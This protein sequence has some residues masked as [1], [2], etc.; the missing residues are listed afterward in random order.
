MISK[1]GRER[2]RAWGK[3]GGMRCGRKKVGMRLVGWVELNRHTWFG[4]CGACSLTQ[5]ALPLPAPPPKHTR[6]WTLLWRSRAGA[7]CA[8]RERGGSA[9]VL[10]KGARVRQ[11]PVTYQPD[12]TI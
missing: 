8:E 1:G 3:A 11:Q 9:G 6:T 5:P 12:I 2:V 7:A 10:D 4:W